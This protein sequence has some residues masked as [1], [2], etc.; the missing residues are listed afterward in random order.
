[1]AWRGNLRAEIGAI[2]ADFARGE[3]R[4]E[5]HQSL[6]AQRLA[7]ANQTR[8]H[9][10]SRAKYNHAWYIA[11]SDYVKE[12][13]KAYY[14]EAKADPERYATLKKKSAAR[15]AKYR[16]KNKPVFSNT[17][18]KKREYSLAYYHRNKHKKKERQS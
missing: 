1:M 2:F 10:G 18:E 9:F 15:Q 11:H 3:E 4:T 16:L 12:R 7:K 14:Q 17:R 6:W 5:F 13:V 8:V